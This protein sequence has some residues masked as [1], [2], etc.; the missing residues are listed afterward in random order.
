MTDQGHNIRPKR[1]HGIGDREIT[2]PGLNPSRSLDCGSIS[3][4]WLNLAR[5]S[6]TPSAWG[7]APP[8]RPVPGTPGDHGDIVSMAIRQYGLNLLHRIRQNNTAR[9]NP[10]SR[11]A[12]RTHRRAVS[13]LE[14]AIRPLEGESL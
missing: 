6:N 11:H 8:E 2:D 14:I 3:T 12:H 1:F 10:M 7:M 13:T 5:L 4:I 9:H